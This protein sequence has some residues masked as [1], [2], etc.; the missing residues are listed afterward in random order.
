MGGG[1]KVARRPITRPPCREPATCRFPTVDKNLTGSA[2]QWS[3]RSPCWLKQSRCYGVQAV[4]VLRCQ[5]ASVPCLLLGAA[6]QYTVPDLAELQRAAKTA[7]ASGSGTQLTEP[8]PIMAQGAASGSGMQLTEPLLMAQGAASD[9]G[10]RTGYTSTQNVV[11]SCTARGKIAM[12]HL[13]RS[14]MEHRGKGLNSNMEHRGKG[15][16]GIGTEHA[17]K[18]LNSCSEHTGG[19][20]ENSGAEDGGK[21]LNSGMEHIGGKG[22]NS[23]MENTDKGKGGSGSGMEHTGSGLNSSTEEPAT[24]GE[25]LGS[26]T[27]DVDEEPPREI[28]EWTVVDE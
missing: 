17:G 23:G 22:L 19:L 18:G 24:Q 16:S 5:H 11:S 10:I 7:T 4:P 15:G 3:L 21:G 14:G 27:G 20:G 26:G 13:L 28:V 2:P 12:K 8:L 25:G 6:M 1:L 9:S